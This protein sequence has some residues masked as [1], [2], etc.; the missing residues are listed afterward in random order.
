MTDRSQPLR[1]TD[2]FAGRAAEAAEAQK[3]A[4]LA[5]GGFTFAARVIDYPGGV[6]GDAGIF[7]G[8]PEKLD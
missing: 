4:E 5:A 3:K 7:I 8:W 1:V 2:L 6:P